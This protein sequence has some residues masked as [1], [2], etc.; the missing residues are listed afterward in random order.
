MGAKCVTV[1]S[2]L[3]NETS[4]TDTTQ[5]SQGQRDVRNRDNLKLM[6]K[7]LGQLQQD[8]EIKKIIRLQQLR[9]I[10]RQIAQTIDKSQVINLLLKQKE[11][12]LV[13]LE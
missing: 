7:E 2:Q 3:H 10:Q 8:T 4:A 12:Y 11:S 5:H 1:Q 13:K 9:K 6:Q